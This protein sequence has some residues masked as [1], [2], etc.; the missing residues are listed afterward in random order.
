MPA[1]RM[2]ANLVARR[3]APTVARAQM[4]PTPPPDADARST[5]VTARPAAKT[6]ALAPPGMRRFRGRAIG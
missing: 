1:L 5:P 3:I 4:E 6:A 2:A